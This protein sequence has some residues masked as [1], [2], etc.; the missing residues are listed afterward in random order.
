[1]LY[2]KCISVAEC[3]NKIWKHVKTYG[4]CYLPWKNDAVMIGSTLLDWRTAAGLRHTDAKETSK[5]RWRTTLI[6]PTNIVAGGIGPTNDTHTHTQMRKKGFNYRCLECGNLLKPKPANLVKPKR[7]ALQNGHVGF[8][9]LAMHALG[10]PLT[11]VVWYFPSPV[12][13]V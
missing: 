8:P 12:I 9:I 11:M 13:R 2:I 10:L 5:N 4:N 6:P 3:K 7:R 1:M